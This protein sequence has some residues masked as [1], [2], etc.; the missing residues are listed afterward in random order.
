M[1]LFQDG[2]E[3]EKRQ[4]LLS[5][6]KAHLPDAEPNA[7][8]DRIEQILE[9]AFE[10]KKNHGKVYN[11]SDGELVKTQAVKIGGRWRVSS[12]QRRWE[13]QY[14]LKRP[15]GGQHV[16]W[17]RYLIAMLGKE[18]V[19]GTGRDP[20]FSNFDSKLSRFEAFAKP[21]LSYLR[22]RNQKN[23]IREYV[24]ERREPNPYHPVK[25]DSS[26]I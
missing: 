1:S 14:L 9:Q 21:F 19:C 20:T 8:A 26:A 7:T 13:E 18:F 10:L 16:R 24:E 11:P 22:V 5:H 3:I 4:R 6:I 12:R 17:P 15:R 25:Y 2:A 23:R